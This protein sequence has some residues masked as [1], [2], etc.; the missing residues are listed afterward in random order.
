M[1]RFQSSGQSRC[2]LR[3]LA[4]KY[5]NRL[6]GPATSV[7]KKEDEREILADRPAL[8]ARLVPV[9]GVVDELEREERHAE[10]QKGA[11]PDPAIGVIARH[12]ADEEVPVLECPENRDARRHAEQHQ[13]DPGA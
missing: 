7:G 6:I 11:V 3:R 9:H 10:R 1:P 12:E 8:D 13:R 5:W 2:G 4:A